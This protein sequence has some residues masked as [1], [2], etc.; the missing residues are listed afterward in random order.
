M[1]DLRGKGQHRSGQLKEADK[2]LQ[3]SLKTSERAT[4]GQ[5]NF[6]TATDKLQDQST[7]FQHQRK[8][9]DA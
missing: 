4:T 6:A 5:V 3:R 7:Q 8:K 9:K 2:L 1:H